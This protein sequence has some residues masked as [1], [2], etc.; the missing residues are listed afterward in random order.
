M[1][2]INIQKIVDSLR[3]AWKKFNEGTTY[4]IY[5]RSSP[6]TALE[7][8]NAQIKTQTPKMVQ[9]SQQKTD[10]II[11]NKPI[12]TSTPTR[13][14]EGLARNPNYK[15]FLI[16]DEVKDALQ[17][18]ATQFEVPQQLL[19]DIALQ[20]SSYDPNKINQQAEPGLNPQGLFQFTDNT[21]QTILDQYNNKTG[22]TLSLP[23]TNRLDPYTNAAAA[24]YLIKHGQLGKWDASEGTW[25]NYWSPQEL[26]DAGFYSQSQYHLPGVRASVRLSGGQ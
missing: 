3:N 5:A 13:I 15:N 16:S 7:Q 25:G 10:A 4:T 2:I 24:A 17:K 6:Q 26:Q 18:A 23:N 21:W 9:V 19:Y 14:N 1:A 20:E 8:A 22:M 11:N 12:T